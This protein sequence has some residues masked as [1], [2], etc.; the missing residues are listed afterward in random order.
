M[1]H[2]EAD[3][4]R[5]QLFL[6]FS[7]MTILIACLGLLGLASYTAEQRAREISIRKVLGATVFNISSILTKEFILMVGVSVLLGF[8]IAFLA[9]NSWL[10]NYAYRISIGYLPFLLAAV[11]SIFI[12]V[13]TIGL[14]I[15]QA[16]TKNP[17]KYLK[18]DG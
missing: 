10:E 5:G 6:G 9:M 17:V 7:G 8:P 18:N 14:Q 4:I 16:A 15:Y 13:S 11:L 12:A 2:Y 1:E 3:Q